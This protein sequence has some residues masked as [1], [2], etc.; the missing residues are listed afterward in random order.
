VL[1]ELLQQVAQST[2]QQAAKS[3]TRRARASK[4]TEQVAEPP[5]CS[6]AGSRR[7]AAEHIG[8]PAFA[9][10][11]SVGQQAEQR[12]RNGRHAA[13]APGAGAAKNVEQTHECLRY[14]LRPPLL[15]STNNKRSERFQLARR[16]RPAACST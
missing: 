8:Q 6:S 4:P 12:H 10:V 15:Q 1:L 13:A 11:G 2:A 9:L 14:L 7:R 5:A 3:T 16:N